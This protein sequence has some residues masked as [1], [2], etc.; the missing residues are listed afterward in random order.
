M[1]TNHTSIKKI[2]SWKYKI[3][4]KKIKNRASRKEGGGG[5][6]LKLIFYLKI[7]C[8]K[9]DSRIGRKNSWKTQF[10]PIRDSSKLF[11]NFNTHQ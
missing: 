5:T 3:T 4:D 10:D 2:F 8:E 11:K 6:K 9:N 7:I 1:W